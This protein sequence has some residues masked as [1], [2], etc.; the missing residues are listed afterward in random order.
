[1]HIIEVNGH[2]VLL[3]CGLCQGHR[4]EAF[5]RNRNI[6]FDVDTID[7]CVLSH[8]HIDHS[9]NLP[10]LVKM[11]YEGPIYATPATQDLCEIMLMDSAYLQVKDVEYVNKKRRKQGKTPF[12]PLYDKG[13]ATR[14]L[15]NFQPL[16]YEDPLEVA[17]GIRVIFHDAGHILG[18][19]LTEVEVKENGSVTRLLYTG[20][21][22]RKEQPILRDP[23]VVRDVDLL[24]TESTY[25]DRL[26][27]QEEDFKDTLEQLCKRTL[28]NSSRMVVPAFSVGR[29]QQLLYYLHALWEEDRLGNIPV[30]VDSPL[31]TKATRVY[32][33]HPECY[34]REMMGHLMDEN[35]PF[36]MQHVTYVTETEDSK[37]LNGR[38]GP[39]IIISASGMCEGGRILHH[40]KHSVEDERNTVLI[41]GYQA[42]NTLGR[43]L[44]QGESPVKIY[45]EEYPLNAQVVSIQALSAHADRDE[46]LGYFDEMG[47]EVDRAFVVHG[48]PAQQEPF[49]ERLKGLGAG[50][51]D[52]PERDQ[53]YTL[54]FG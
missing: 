47:P 21:L 15:E 17:P 4:K 50:T 28:E 54:D 27:P 14:A 31:S 39:I 20:D 7:A 30:Y 43:R 10:N 44:I 19:A 51:V 23:V 3:D 5:E 48:E 25:G 35:S 32:E 29:T 38:Q 41:V 12:E 49:A 18:A 6:P 13:D 45:G 8:A 2:R 36:T 53:T 46:M 37:K 34:D 42:E 16:P 33:N 11:G 22:G 9:G 24:I 1:M 52:I 26:H 40:L